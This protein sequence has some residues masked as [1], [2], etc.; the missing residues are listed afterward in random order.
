MTR[1]GHILNLEE[2]NFKSFDIYNFEI[3]KFYHPT[4]F[5]LTALFFSSNS[6]GLLSALTD[7]IYMYV[8][9]I[10]IFNGIPANHLVKNN[11]IN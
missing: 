1:G 4:L 5:A 2:R 6:I 11:N 7:V 9:H 3:N 10:H 8:I